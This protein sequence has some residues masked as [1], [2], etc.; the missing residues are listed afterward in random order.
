MKKYFLKLYQ[1]NTWANNRVLRCLETQG[2]ADEKILSLMGHIVAAQFLW[3]YR[4]KALPPP[5]V[6]LWSQDSLPHITKQAVEIGKEWTDFIE[7]T[8]NKAVIKA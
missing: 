7:N 6:K 2:V 1:Y 8:S 5:N 4:I 3:L